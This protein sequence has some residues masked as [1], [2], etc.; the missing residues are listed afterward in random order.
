[1]C[2]CMLKLRLTLCHPVDC[3]LPG[4]SVHSKNTGAGCHFL[5]LEIFLTQGSNPH[6]L[7]LLHWQADSLPC[8][9]ENNKNKE[10]L[11]LAL[12][13]SIAPLLGQVRG[14][15]CCV[16]PLCPNLTRCPQASREPGKREVSQDRCQANGPDCINHPSTPTQCGDTAVGWAVGLLQMGCVEKRCLRNPCGRQEGGSSLLPP[17]PH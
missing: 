4:S 11:Y 15:L 5:L 14:Y 17:V 2:V 6:L 16:Y 12:I 3:N 8:H 10:T 1:M 13:Y 9:L 7:H